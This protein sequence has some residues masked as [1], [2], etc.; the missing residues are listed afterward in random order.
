MK[1]SRRVAACLL[2]ATSRLSFTRRMPRAQRPRPSL[3]RCASRRSRRP[4]WSR[5]TSSTTITASGAT[6]PAVTSANRPVSRPWMRPGLVRTRPRLSRPREA[7]IGAP[8]ARLF[9]KAT[10]I[11]LILR[12]SQRQK[13]SRVSPTIVGSTQVI[14]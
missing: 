11:D 9:H 2:P 1:C 6:R 12:S 3:A 14:R 13:A 8:A 5:T 7:I 10:L 4:W